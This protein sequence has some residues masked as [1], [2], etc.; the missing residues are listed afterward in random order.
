M[1]VPKATKKILFFVEGGIGKNIVATSVVRAIKKQYPEK[2][3]I[4]IAGCPEVFYNNPNVKRT[5]NFGNPLYLYEDQ[6][7]IES[8][9]FRIEPYYHYD[10][11]ANYII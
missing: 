3:I 8:V 6:V 4:V 2:D 1:R 7:G 5:Y 11:I 9:V 10:Y